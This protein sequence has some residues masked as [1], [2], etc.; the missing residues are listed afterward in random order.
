MQ[1]KSI[2][3]LILTFTVFLAFSCDSI[4]SDM[5]KNKKELLKDGWTSIGPVSYYKVE[6]TN[7]S[8][9]NGDKYDDE[10]IRY[11]GTCY[12]FV[13]LIGDNMFVTVLEKGRRYQA[14]L[15]SS[16]FI[17]KRYYYEKEKFLSGW[18]IT[19]NC[20]YKEDCFSDSDEKEYR[21]FF[22]AY[23]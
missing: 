19:V 20:V 22:L 9:S 8:F 3:L 14:T 17:L 23:L 6:Y 21:A 10:L 13:K 12:P 5:R 1:T 7:Y 11:S 4:E 16:P 15:F 18:D 2:L